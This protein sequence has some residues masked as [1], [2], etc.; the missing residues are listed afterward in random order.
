MTVTEPSTENATPQIPARLD[1]DAQAPDAARALA[2]LDQ[3][4]TRELDQAGIDQQLREL[5][6]IRASQL[7]GCAYCID[8]HTKDARAAGETEQRLYALTAWRETP[9]FTDRERAALAF[10]ETVTLMA[11]DHVPAADYDAA[12]A[13]FSPREMAALLSL[14][15]TINAWNAVGVTARAWVPGSYQP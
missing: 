8:M 9:F 15:V 13:W 6:R 1:F 11:R 7:N 3:A 10:T 12:A 14:V 2:R 4:T 5:V